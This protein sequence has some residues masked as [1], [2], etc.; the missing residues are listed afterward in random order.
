[1]PHLYFSDHRARPVVVSVDQAVG[2][3]CPNRRADVLLVQFLLRVVDETAGRNTWIQTRRA[4]PMMI[5][6][7]FG[8]ITASYI[9][10]F[11][12]QFPK[13]PLAKDGRVDPFSNGSWW[14]PRTGVFMT[15][16]A[17]NMAYMEA[18]GDDAILRIPHHGWFPRELRPM[19]QIS[20]PV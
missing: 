13:Y 9:E 14:G 6:G 18:L 3:G 5:D 1:M 10:L 4:K 16:A 12:R 11:Q 8:D 7:R 15:M 19:M 20:I 17:I 2:P